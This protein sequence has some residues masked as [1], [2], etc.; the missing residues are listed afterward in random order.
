MKIKSD[1]LRT[2]QTIHTWTGITAGL[3]LFIGFFAGSLTM[4]S[5]AID[6]WATPPDYQLQ[7][8]RPE[9]HNE[10]L[11]QVF[12][13]YPETVKNVTISYESNSSPIYWYG[14]GS[15]RGFSLDDKMWHGTLDE[16][17]QLVTELKH[18][19]ELSM[20]VDYLHRSAGIVGELGHDQAGVYILGIAAFLYFIALMSGLIFLLPSL[21]KSFFA[22]RKEKGANRFWLDSHN[23]V[24]IAS[25][26][27]HIII[28][29][30]VVV[31]SFHDLFY[32]GLSQVYGNKPL[33]GGEDKHHEV[34]YEL[35]D[36]PTLNEIHAK[37]AQYAPGFSILSI[38]LRGLTGEH[39]SASI[40]IVNDKSFMRGPHNDFLFMNPYTLEIDTSSV[41]NGNGQQGIWG[42]VV[43]TF[44]GLH[45]GS[46][47]G[48]LGRWLYF[49]MGLGG[50]FLFYSGN[51]IWLE[52]RRKKQSTE[53]SKSSHFMA[54]LT[55][56][57]C[58][59][60]AIGIAGAFAASKWLMLGD[61]NINVAYM[62]VYYALFLT[63]IL[64]AFKF[65]AARFS[66]F[67]FYGLAAL[68]LM[69]P[70][71]SLIG[72]IPQTGIWL[73]TS[74]SD[75]GVEIGSI[76]FAIASMLAAKKVK[77]RVYEGEKN[78]IWYCSKYTSEQPS[79]SLA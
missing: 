39:P 33:F 24:G 62:W 59:G 69:I 17:G 25:L 13:D 52:K 10:L 50:A 18:V 38:N 34:R 76:G 75:Y 40:S 51:L 26:P 32:S 77:K 79:A 42:A 27:F 66:I 36:L 72:F 7:Q 5:N 20:L 43:T 1:V 73:P 28:A 63:S 74:A 65:G 57:V 67:G 71:T 49:I 41:T 4:F 11:N 37:V 60:C 2:Y 61:W 64:T 46:Y 14:S 21:V 48:E 9:L 8:I 55:V 45:F 16:Y 68:C 30:T 19:N 31:F 35:E 12:A 15:A 22:L 29:V 23:L 70:I 78:S 56:G 54:N 58:L 3:L 47:G 44:F 53:Q 6:D